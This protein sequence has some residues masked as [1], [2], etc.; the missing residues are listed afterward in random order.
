M[1]WADNMIVTFILYM[2]GTGRGVG[3]TGE[4]QEVERL[5]QCHLTSRWQRQGSNLPDSKTQA[6]STSANNSQAASGV[7]VKHAR[8]K[9]EGLC[10]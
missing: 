6:L 1:R 4:T 9:A 3:E 5:A 7:D 2:M 10:G 8:P